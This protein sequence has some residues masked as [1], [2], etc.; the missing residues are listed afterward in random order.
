V[1]VRGFLRSIRRALTAARTPAGVADVW[2]RQSIELAR[3]TIIV[4]AFYACTAFLLIEWAPD[5]AE[6]TTVHTLEPLWPLAWAKW[7]GIETAIAFVHGSSLACALFAAIMP[8]LRAARL[9][10]AVTFMLEAALLNSRT[11]TVVAHGLHPWLWT[12]LLFVFLPSGTEAEIAASRPRSQRY[13]RVFAGAQATILMFYSLSGLLKIAGAA[14]QLSR[15]EV[16]A[17]AAEALARHAAYRLLEGAD[18]SGF[19]AVGPWLVSHPGAGAMIFPLAIYLETCSFLVAFRPALHRI[20]GMALIMMHLGTYFVLTILF[21][22]Q[23]LLLGLLL[24]ASPFTPRGNSVREVV[25]QLPL[26]GDLRRLRPG[27]RVRQISNASN[28]S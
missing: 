16:H 26:L 19:F 15:G 2:Q 8:H 24:L 1:T 18:P 12:A 11:G 20:W 6:W 25:D 5:W 23:I 10:A 21:S 3:A 9:A 4:R 27:K 7:T 14:V 17:F 13:L 22:V 28:L